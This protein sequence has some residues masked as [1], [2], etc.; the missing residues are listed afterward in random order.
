MD[1]TA[2]DPRKAWLAAAA[3]TVMFIALAAL[4]LTRTGLVSPEVDLGP[5]ATV[6]GL[7]V[8]V[9][10]IVGALIVGRTRAHRVG[11]LLVAL[12][13]MGLLTELSREYAVY[14]L[15][16]SPGTLPF[17]PEAAWLWDWI[18]IGIV[19]MI[20]PLLLYFPDG[21]L[22]SR[23]WRLVLWA[24]GLCTALF[25]INAALFTWP[26]RGA[27]LLDP[28]YL[29]PEDPTTL[30]QAVESGSIG[31]LV[32]VLGAGAVSLILRYRR[33]DGIERHQ[34]KW[35]ATA[36]VFQL[37]AI[38]TA[39]VLLGSEYAALNLLSD[40]ITVGIVPVAVGVAI[41]K[42]RLY[43]IDVV[44]NKA[45][46]Y[47]VLAVFISAIYVGIVVGI[48]SRIGAGDEP[49]LGLSVVATA[50]I[51]IAFQ[52]FRL[53]VQRLANRLVYGKRF[54]PYEV[55]AEFSNKMT[56][57]YA[58]DELL[59]QMAQTLAGGTGA[60]SSHVWIK[61]GNQ[62]RLAASFHRGAGHEGGGHESEGDHH[63]P[64]PLDKDE[65]VIPDSDRVVRVVHKGE[66]LG[67]LAITKRPG[68]Q[69]S[70]VEDK[71]MQDLASQAGVVL[72]NVRLTEELLQKLD[73]LQAS[74][75]RLVAAQDKARRRLERDLHDGAQQQLVALKVKLSLAQ[76]LT[77]QE[78]VRT[79]LT[80]LQTEADDTLQT[81]RDL[82]RGIYPPLLADKG[83]TTAL[84]AQAN[85]SPIEVDVRGEGIGRY[86]QEVEAA[87]YFC[88]LEALQNVAKYA[89]E[90]EVT[91]TLEA[92]QDMLTFEVADTGC[93]FDMSAS[94]GGHG[95]QN[96]SDRVDALG[97]ALTVES[98]EGAG[99]KVTG[100]IPARA[101]E[102]A[103]A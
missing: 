33:S 52:P 9:S 19:A 15:I 96:M 48:G 73:E 54:T 62:L 100:R 46:V 8:F 86:S 65:P 88:C 42:Y 10:V 56:G 76:R 68:E 60:A 20:P 67:A 75:Q 12:G 21:R 93:G 14:A 6:L 81:L 51:A 31:L 7:A 4:Q 72:R 66:L 27:D 50:L 87:V 45:L 79:F 74:R 89:G 43:D 102:P 61:V 103:P 71:L 77:T 18:W 91:V 90:C 39:Y 11:W 55:L 59:A 47:G 83:L 38:L 94:G 36:P 25:F 1:R 35:L 69:T 2:G 41:F 40:L 97:G 49:N 70:P 3:G 26:R 32:F 101:L 30:S 23:R 63:A 28:G 22:L 17:G 57:T 92:T 34:L 98:S 64:I 37:M 44:I 58:Q 99:T 84:V 16:R 5:N 85:K 53:R 13:L 29:P 95:L 78:K 80:Q 82:A 24:D